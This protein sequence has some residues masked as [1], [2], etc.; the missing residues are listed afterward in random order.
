MSVERALTFDCGSQKLVGI[1]C[2]PDTDAKVGVLVVVGGPQY[3]VG[4]HRQFVLLSRAIA[5]SGM[6]VMRF[7]Y[8]GMGDSGG[9]TQSFEQTAPDIAAAIDAFMNACP[10]LER[11]VLWGLCDGASA[12]L[13]YWHATG[14]LRVAGMVLLNPWISSDENFARAQIRQSFQ[15]VLQASFWR[16]VLGGGV[17]VGGAVRKLA[18]AVAAAARR[19]GGHAR[20]KPFQ[21]RMAEGLGAFAGP[22]LIVLSG[23]DLAAMEFAERSRSDPRWH[24]VVARANVEQHEIGD[25]DHTFSDSARRLDA[26]ARVCAW[27]ARS[28]QPQRT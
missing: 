21:E 17:D 9:E 19:N 1:Y 7:D 8:R 20:V 4:C 10:S 28:F 15:R 27:L 14:D 25:A 16:E 12:S 26:E 18:S 13:L 3:R 24:E 5:E 23:R 2:C 22:V 6:P 11:V